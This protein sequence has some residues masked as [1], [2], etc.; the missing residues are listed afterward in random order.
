[1]TLCFSDSNHPGE[2]KNSSDISN[3]NLLSSS[4]CKETGDNRRPMVTFCISKM[5]SIGQLFDVKFVAVM[6]LTK[7][8]LIASIFLI[9]CHTINIH[10]Q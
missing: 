2:I 6:E 10:K 7:K 3:L 4:L 9:I 5:N 8:E 1:M